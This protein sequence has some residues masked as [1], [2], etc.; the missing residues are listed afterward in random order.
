[1]PAHLSTPRAAPCGIGKYNAFDGADSRYSCTNCA[2]GRYEDTNL[3]NQNLHGVVGAC[4]KAKTPTSCGGGQY[5]VKGTSTTSDDYECKVCEAGKHKSG[6]DAATSCKAKTPTTC[7]GGRYLSKGTSTTSDDYECKVCPPGRFKSGT[8]SATQCDPFDS[9]QGD[10]RNAL[11]MV[12]KGV[13]TAGQLGRCEGDCDTDSGCQGDL[14]C[15]QRDASENVPGCSGGGGTAYDY[16]Y[17]REWAHAARTFAPAAA[18]CVLP[19]PYPCTS[20]PL[21]SCAARLL[22]SPADAHTPHAR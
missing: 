1:M 15:F 8:S 10:P 2:A 7:G 18:T 22:P 6:T 21:P 5:L 11:P 19:Q 20:P 14:K 4:S 13:N 12:W 3:G 16:C 17:A 9:C